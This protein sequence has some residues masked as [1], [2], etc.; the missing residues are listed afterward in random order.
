MVNILS[1]INVLL[2]LFHFRQ[3][4]PQQKRPEVSIVSKKF[5]ENYMYYNKMKYLY[6]LIILEKVN[7]FLHAL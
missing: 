4:W 6:K 7:L 2:S 5:F 1:M 3:G